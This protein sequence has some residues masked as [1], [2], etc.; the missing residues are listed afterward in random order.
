MINFWFYQTKLGTFSIAEENN[1]LIWIGL[2]GG[3]PKDLTPANSQKKESDLIKKAASQIKDYLA[4][5]IKKFNLPL[6]P[7]GTPFQLKVWAALQQVP[8]GKTASYKDIAQK[9]GC[10]KGFRAVGMAN[11]KNPLPIVIPCHRIIGANGSL[12][13]YGGGLDIKRALLDL[14]GI[15]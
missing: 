13:G 4:G 8:Y 14:E 10:P 2:S 7:K 12:T 3:L 11:N 9:A 1:K 5:K 6:A 15:K